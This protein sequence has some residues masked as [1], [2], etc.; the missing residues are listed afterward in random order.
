MS[1]IQEILASILQAVYGKD[2]RQAIHDG[3]EMAYNKADD[4]ATSAAAAAEAASGS[5]ESA[6]A[7]AQAA[8]NSASS[9]SDSADLAEQYKN[10]AFHTTPAGY[11]AF[12]GE[13]NSSLDDLYNNGVK[14]LLQNNQGT[15]NSGHGVIGTYNPSDGTVSCSGTA[16]DN[17]YIRVAF[18]FPLKA[19]KYTL[20]GCPS[21][22]GGSTYRL[23]VSNPSG[24]SFSDAEYDIGSGVSFTVTQD[25]TFNCSIYVTNGQTLSNVIFK[26]MITRMG[27]PNSD[28]AHYVPYAQTNVALTERCNP[29]TPQKYTSNTSSANV[30]KFK[31]ADCQQSHRWS[32]IALGYLQGHGLISLL[33][34]YNSSTLTIT[35][36]KDGSAFSSS[37]IAI[38]YSESSREV[39]ITY[40]VGNGDNSLIF[41]G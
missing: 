4:A 11:E 40:S 36:I 14:N 23:Y 21:G 29:L 32:G 15:Y 31:I 27:V 24:I 1:S 9:A 41:L 8:S 30:H 26:P 39:T 16:T 37:G 22:G 20:S 35:D 3:V 38:T 34:Q 6:A 18:G 17:C 12:V 2:V 13:V 25:D 28:Y 5:Q 19:G 33:L 10:E 7:S